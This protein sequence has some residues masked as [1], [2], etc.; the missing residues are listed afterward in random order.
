M[1]VDIEFIQKF[2]RPVTL[3]EMKADPDLAG[4][5]LAQRGSR[6]SVQPVAEA[7]FRRICEQGR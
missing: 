1:M 4:L 6:L 3:A 7:H 2:A 5:M